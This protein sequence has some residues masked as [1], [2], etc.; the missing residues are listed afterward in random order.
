MNP[1]A[2]Q[3]YFEGENE[4]CKYIGDSFVYLDEGETYYDEFNNMSVTLL[5]KNEN[6]ALV[7]ISSISCVIPTNGMSITQ[8][9]TFCPGTYSMPDGLVIESDN[10]E[11]DCKG[12][13][14]IG[15]NQGIS[16]Y[17]KSGV[18][19]KNCKLKDYSTAIHLLESQDN[20][21]G[22]NIIDSNTAIKLM[23]SNNNQ[24]IQ[25]KIKGQGDYGIK[26]QLSTSNEL[27]S[28]EITNI[29]TGISLEYN[30]YQNELYNNNV[31][32]SEIDIICESQDNIGA[33][34]KFNEVSGCENIGFVS[35]K[36]S[37]ELPDISTGELRKSQPSFW[38]RI[39]NFFKK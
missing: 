16:L 39:L 35:C 12:A 23:Q 38:Q 34:N 28:N 1:N 3:C 19:I 10:I 17:Q 26:L 2:E 24:I 4:I 6:G 37:E 36:P 27:N 14:L 29:G 13:E 7:N 32:N 18:T 21:I 22:N 9:T 15:E 8:D 11:L 20:T 25:N 30:S 33:N 5:E 31:C